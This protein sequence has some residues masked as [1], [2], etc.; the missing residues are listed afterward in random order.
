VAGQTKGILFPCDHPRDIA[1]VGIVA[2]Q[3]VTGDKGGMV[4]TT[5]CF[6]HQILMALD[7]QVRARGSEQLLSG[8]AMGTMAGAA[9]G[10]DHRPVGVSL[11]KLR[12]QVGVARIADPVGPI[13][14]D[15]LQIGAVRIVARIALS[16][17]KGRMFVLCL[18][19]LLGLG[20][21]GETQRFA[22]RIEK[23]LILRRM[24]LMAGE[25]PLVARHRR[26]ADR[27]LFL[28]RWV[29]LEAKL[30]PL[31]RKQLRVLRGMRFVAGKALTILERLMF[32]SSPAFQTRGIMTVSAEFRSLL[33]RLK[34][35]LRFRPLVA[36]LALPAGYGVMSARLEEFG[37]HGGMRVVA[38]D[39]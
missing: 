16:A 20:M 27:D 21:A 9:V 15:T 7:A 13:L 10:L 26:M 35:L 38:S 5:L 34:R 25:T 24:G 1:P 14:E 18:L 31:P 19:L 17:N 22:L 3:T 6:L 12:L 30:V 4:G 28:H 8:S 29:A 36:A 11:Q 37:L 33:G 39:T 32:E 2:G 23:E